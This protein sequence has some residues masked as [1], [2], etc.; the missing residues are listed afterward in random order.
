MKGGYMPAKY[1]LVAS[2]ASCIIVA[3]ALR[4]LY[5]YRN[6]RA[7]RLGEPAMSQVEA[8]AVR[9]RLSVEFSDPGYR[10]EY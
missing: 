6:R 1:T 10:Y 4:L 8:K 3:V 9:G 2:T 7:E 5:G